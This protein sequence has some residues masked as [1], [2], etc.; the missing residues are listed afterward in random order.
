MAADI[1]M[2]APEVSVVE[3]K[4]DGGDTLEYRRFCINELRPALKDIVL[5]SSDSRATTV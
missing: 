1:F 2:V 3:V 4:K 5:A